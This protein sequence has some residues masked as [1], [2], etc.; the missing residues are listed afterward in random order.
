MSRILAVMIVVSALF[1]M[2]AATLP[3]AAKTD[4]VFA[5]L[6][7]VHGT[8]VAAQAEYRNR[9]VVT[10]N[11]DG[12]AEKKNVEPYLRDNAVTPY[13]KAVE[14]FNHANELRKVFD[15]AVALH[16]GISYARKQFE[17][18]LEVALIDVAD[19]QRARGIQP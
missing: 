5:Q 9:A 2:T 13:L 8:L 18:A 19:L 10:T 11:K 12:V 16:S 1:L 17:K 15:Q 4:T 7:A 6:V 3:V 14:S